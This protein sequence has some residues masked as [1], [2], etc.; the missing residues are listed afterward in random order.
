MW[1]LLLSIL[2]L[3]AIVLFFDPYTGLMFG[4]SA[5]YLTTALQKWIPPDR[6]FVYG[7]ILRRLTR[8]PQSLFPMIVL[9]TF[10]SAIASWLVS[11]SLIRFFQVRFSVAA[12]V[13]LLCAIEPL[14]L[15]FE[16]FI[17]PDSLSTSLFALLMFLAFHYLERPRLLLLAGI[18]AVL[19]ILASLRLNYISI[20]I[21]LSLLLPLLTVPSLAALS[22]RSGRDVLKHLLLPLIVSVGLSQGL[23][24]GYRAFYGYMIEKPPAYSYRDGEFA[25]AVVV[26]LVQ[27]SDFP[28]TV[29]GAAIMNAVEIPLQDP[30]FRAA[31]HWMDAGL[32]AAIKRAVGDDD[33]A[34]EVMRH[35]A[36]NAA[37]RN[38]AGV[39]RLAWLVYSEFFDYRR[40]Q[41][42]LRIEQGQENSAT[43]EQAAVLLS[44]FNHDVQAPHFDSPTKRWHSLAFPWYWFLLVLPLLY[45]VYLSYW[46][47]GVGP[48][49]VLCGLMVLVTVLQAVALVERPVTRYLTSEAWLAMVMLGGLFRRKSG[50]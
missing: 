40:L 27:P 1:L 7:F 41:E 47:H 34:N 10:L 17:L 50:T 9:Q 24:F 26:P 44:A 38:P 30:K 5:S 35:T 33:R 39:V 11:V 18:H 46:R 45:G 2:L 49:H 4:D 14:Q 15:M 23:L 42:N 19:V 25:L 43:P 48:H 28:E 32:C 16:R 21:F 36:L 12:L 29:D 20:A 6:S 37:L 3:K 22:R 13:G 8:V 31:H